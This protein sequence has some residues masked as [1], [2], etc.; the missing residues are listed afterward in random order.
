MLTDGIAELATNE[1]TRVYRARLEEAR[2]KEEQRR[3]AA[4]IQ[5]TILS[6]ADVRA[7]QR[8]GRGSRKEE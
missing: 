6:E 5:F 4:Q 7:L 8:S 1:E 2:K 3:K